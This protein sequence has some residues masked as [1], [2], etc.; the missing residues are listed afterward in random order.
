MFE[1]IHNPEEKFAEYKKMRTF[2]V[3]IQTLGSYN[4]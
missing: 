1:S 3:P 4:G 2:A